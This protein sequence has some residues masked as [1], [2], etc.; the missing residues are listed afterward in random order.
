[1]IINRDN[2]KK[3]KEE[4]LRKYITDEELNKIKE[5]IYKEAEEEIKQ[6]SIVEEEEIDE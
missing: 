2:L 5:K 1:M 4:I 6:F 3:I